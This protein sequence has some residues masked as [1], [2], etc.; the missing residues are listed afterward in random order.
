MK[1]MNIKKRST[2]RTLNLTSE[3]RTS[4]GIKYR[5]GRLKLMLSNKDYQWMDWNVDQS[6][7]NL[8][9]QTRLDADRVRL[10]EFFIPQVMMVWIEK[11]ILTPRGGEWSF[12]LVQD[13]RFALVRAIQQE[14]HGLSVFLMVKQPDLKFRI[15][16]A[17]SQDSSTINWG[18]FMRFMSHEVNIFDYRSQKQIRVADLDGRSWIQSIEFDDAVR[19]AVSQNAPNSLV[20]PS[21]IVEAVDAWLR[22][23]GRFD[24]KLFEQCL[25]GIRDLVIDAYHGIEYVHIK[26]DR[27]RPI[28]SPQSSVVVHLTGDKYLRVIKSRKIVLQFLGDVKVKETFTYEVFNA[29]W[30]AYVLRFLK[31][32]VTSP[33]KYLPAILEALSG[34]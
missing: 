4:I 21:H 13:L 26:A 16:M 3:F 34:E 11:N 29:D 33:K 17:L 2:T 19:R 27:K 20:L 32:K 31:G 30:E 23:V 22:Y 8:M 5:S 1:K 18:L 24:A 9:L 10:P 12:K 14:D 15:R 25:K 28:P 6:L 7:R